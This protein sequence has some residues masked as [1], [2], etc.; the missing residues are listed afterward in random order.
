MKFSSKKILKKDGEQSRLR[1]FTKKLK[2][3]YTPKLK[4]KRYSRQKH[5]ELRKFSRT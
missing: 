5:Q 2:S 3:H 1:K 4:L